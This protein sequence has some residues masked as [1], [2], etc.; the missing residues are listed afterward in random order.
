MA[1]NNAAAVDQEEEKKKKKKFLIIIII[2]MAAVILLL[3]GAVVMLLLGDNEQA[4]NPNPSQDNHPYFNNG[5]LSYDDNAF[6]FDQ[7]ALQSQLD[8]LYQKVE[9][10]YISISHKN[11]AVSHDGEYFECYIQNGIDNKY[12]MFI[13]IY[14]DNTAQEQLLLTGLIRPGE[15]IDHFKSEIKLKP[16]KYEAL[17]VITQVEDDHETLRDA[18][19]FLA[20]HLTVT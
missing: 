14:K 12:D 6:A 18:Q 10:G 13:N 9:D 2:I 20:L 5:Q 16:G 4:P 7:D 11:E 8:A 17:L 19:L 3:G 15:G 1:N